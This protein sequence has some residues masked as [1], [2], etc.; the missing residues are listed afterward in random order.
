MLKL[1]HLFGTQKREDLPYRRY[2]ICGLSNRAIAQ[3]ALPLLGSKALPEYGD[4]SAYGKLVGILDLD[5]QR[6]ADFN[7]AMGIN[8]PI[9]RPEDFDRM[10]DET[11]PD[12]VLVGTPDGLHVD[13]IVQGLRR[14]LAVITE[15]PMVIDCEQG[16]R[17]LEAER[18]SKAAVRVTFNYRYTQ[19][20]M[21]IK[22]LLMGGAIGRITN[23]ELAWNIDTFHGSSYFYRWNRERDKSGGLSISKSC[24]HFDLINWWLNDVPEQVFAFGA[25]NYYGARSPY[26]PT[27]PGGQ[28]LP[29]AQQVEQCPYQQY[30]NLPG[31]APPKDD[32][33]TAHQRVF[34]LPYYKQ[35]REH[36]PKYI[37]DEE[38][39]IEDTYS[40]V[41][42]Y[43]GG[44]SMTYSANFSAAWEGYTLGIN[45]TH[46]RLE[47]THLVAPGRS[48]WAADATETIA[49]YPL[50][51][52][53]QVHSVRRVSGGHGGAD[54]RLKYDLYVGETPQDR[55]LGCM[56][57]A[58]DGVYAVAIGE[59]VW[60]SVVE[61]RVINIEQLLGN[62]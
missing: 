38:I 62:R 5:T 41:V 46:G 28:A 45:G 42:R 44:A 19:L 26:K 24:H 11:H 36:K 17:V 50:F 25:L 21:A 37:Y 33:L 9:Y 18:R 35:Y 40:A 61:K 59:A 16:R 32:H 52:Q 34:Q 4:Y 55:E 48:P 2:V 56:A 6:V 20:H 12:V 27:G 39:G 29:F 22:R 43:R 30:W 7:A 13:Y 53:R 15:K 47:T 49:V 8:L 58:R 31:M 23:V 60:R 14:D 3:F 10:I 1:D 54:P 51:G 57:G